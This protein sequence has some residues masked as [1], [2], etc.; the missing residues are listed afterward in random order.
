[1]KKW[2]FVLVVIVVSE[3]SWSQNKINLIKLRND[4]VQGRCES[5]IPTLFD[6]SYENKNKYSADDI[7]QTR[8]MLGVCFFKMGLYHAAAFPLIGNSYQAKPELALKAVDLL[9]RITDK[10]SDPTLLSYTVNKLDSNLKTQLSEDLVS[11]KMGE[12]KL[13]QGQLL[14][15]EEFFKKVLEKSKDNKSALYQLGLVYLKT[16][17]LKQAYG[18]FEQL[19]QL[20]A[21]SK[22]TSYEKGVVSLALARTLYQAK[23]W[24]ESIDAYKVIP[25]NHELYRQA[26]FEMAWA[27]FRSMK[28]RAAAGTMETLQSDFYTHVFDPESLLLRMTIQL[29][30]CQ[31]E[32]LQNSMKVYEGQYM[33]TSTLIQQWLVKKPTTKEI[34]SVILD[35]IKRKK[36]ISLGYDVEL[37][38]SVPY[39]VLRTGLDSVYVKP[40]LS[41]L[42]NLKKEKQTFRKLKI[43]KNQRLSRFVE[44]IYKN[45]V[46]SAN[47]RLVE[48]FLKY[49]DVTKT[50]VEQYNK[51][52]DFIKYEYLNAKRV[53]IKL[54]SG[55][56][57][58]EKKKLNIN[59]QRDFYWENG[60]RYWP[61][62]G[63]SW[64]DEVGNYQFVGTNRCLND[65]N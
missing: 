22:E 7:F 30:I 52:F 16:N 59:P 5:V 47:A 31:F 10:V 14:E 62:Q 34:Y 40:V 41:I 8:Q 44:R 48:G 32:D 18:L 4:V 2:I 58:E 38:S 23:M 45:R 56:S 27:Q 28:F 64:V 35:T 12:Y 63:E 42:D 37:K 39:F 53:N 1:M 29:F 6:I 65:Q 26:L 20:Q 50:N 51:Q 3:V 15:A 9:L 49:L 25:R 61:F 54:Q 46:S 21:N 19:D 43:A 13:A 24:T 60:Y 55:L 11:S 17:K 33:G 36:M 57:E